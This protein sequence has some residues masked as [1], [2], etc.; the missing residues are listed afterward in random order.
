[1]FAVTKQGGQ[2]MAAPDVCNTP[3]PVTGSPIPIPYPN[4]AMPP[5]GNPATNKVLISGMP[6]L[7]KSSQ[8]SLSS[9]DE[10]GVMGGAVSGKNMGMTE[11]IMGSMKVQLEGNPAVRLSDPTKHNDGNTVGA[12]VAP[13]QTKVMIMS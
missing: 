10:A 3:D 5:M 13:S 2:C 1:M 9:G 4:M 7:T 12:V 11:F 6:A 8:I